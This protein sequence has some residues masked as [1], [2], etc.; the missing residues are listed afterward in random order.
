M[1]NVFLAGYGNVTVDAPT[2]A[3]YARAKQIQ[4]ETLV[5]EVSTGITYYAKQIPGVFSDKEF[6]T[7]LLLSIFLGSL[8]VDRFYLGQSGLGVGKLL[9][10]LFSC[11]TVGWIW[12]Q[13]V[14]TQVLSC[15][16][17]VLE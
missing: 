16:R 3:G 9:V 13:N 5:V 11:G 15:F 1:Y 7:A 10:T 12:N 8:G 4:G 2:L 14:L 17:S 6:L